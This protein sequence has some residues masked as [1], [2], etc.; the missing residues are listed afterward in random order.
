VRCS[1]ESEL[2]LTNRSACL[3]SGAVPYRLNDWQLITYVPALTK[4]S[5]IGCQHNISGHVALAYLMMLSVLGPA[6]LA[7][8]ARQA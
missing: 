5:T 2:L 3:R 4:S 1:P 7:L 6:V 8:F